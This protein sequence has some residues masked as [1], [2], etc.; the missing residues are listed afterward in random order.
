MGIPYK[1]NILAH[2]PPGT[3]KTSLAKALACEFN[4]HLHIIIFTP[5]MDDESFNNA[6]SSIPP[7]SILVI[8]DIDCI[9]KDRKDKDTLGN[10]ISMSGLLNTLDGIAYSSG[11]ITFITTNYVKYIDSALIRPGRIDKRIKF[12]Y[13]KKTE[14]IKMFEKFYPENQES[15][16]K[17]LNII[18]E[19][20]NI[21]AANLQQYLYNHFMNKTNPLELKHLKSYFSVDL[22]T[23]N[24]DGISSMY[25]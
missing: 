18:S 7:N 6:I 17:L 22:D 12:S 19:R 15:I 23:D 20:G 24:F 8:E 13:I 16:G 11:L 21:T 14:A 3:G 25:A 5:K 2:G 1:Y 9:F 10:K 4:L